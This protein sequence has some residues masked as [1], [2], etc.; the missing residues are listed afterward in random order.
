MN[1][2]C[3]TDRK[4]TRR[5]IRNKI[6]TLVKKAVEIS[7]SGCEILLIINYQETRNWI[8]YSSSESESLFFR[9]QMAKK[10]LEK[11]EEYNNTNYEKF[12]S[13]LGVVDDSISPRP[14][15]LLKSR[16]TFSDSQTIKSAGFGKIEKFD[17]GA[18]STG[19]TST[20]CPSIF[21]APTVK[22]PPDVQPSSFI[23]EEKTKEV[24]ENSSS[25][26]DFE[27]YFSAAG[28]T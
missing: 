2:K 25:E 14:S 11:V 23:F 19:V 17:E 12:S 20:V 4:A 27:T 6:Q 18:T 26:F 28:Q 7:D 1:E 22:K 21:P 15:K 5:K 8:Q 9:F 10:D 16:D 24:E 3:R 13:S